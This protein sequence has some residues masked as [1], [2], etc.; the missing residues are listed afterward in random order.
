MQLN[1]KTWNHP[2]DQR[3]VTFLKVINKLIIN[4]FF[5]EFI[6]HKKRTN[7]AVAFS[8]RCLPNI[9]KYCYHIWNF[10][11]IR[12][13]RFIQAQIEKNSAN[14]YESSGSVFSAELP[15]EQKENKKCLSNQ[16]WLWLYL[17]NLGVREILCS[18]SL[19]LEGKAGKEMPNYQD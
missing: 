7:R 3:K 4:K 11:K 5:K 8:C 13:S 17:T 12:R 1:E 14:T 9:L 19:V 15:L 10:P 6:N 2:W 16:N 18:F